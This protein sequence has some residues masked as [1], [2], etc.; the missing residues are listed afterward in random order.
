MTNGR[1][2]KTRADLFDKSALVLAYDKNAPLKTL[3][4]K[5]LRERMVYKAEEL[6]T[7]RPLP[8][9]ILQTWARI[10]HFPRMHWGRGWTGRNTS[11]PP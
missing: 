9:F 5:G 11:L 3:R 1:R 7:T 2:Y 6:L 10:L 4:S 8:L